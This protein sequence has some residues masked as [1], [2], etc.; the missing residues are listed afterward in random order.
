MLEHNK[1]RV[2]V[3]MASYNGLQYIDAQI[4]SI[5]DQVDCEITL[6][7]SV[8]KSDDNTFYH[9]QNFKKNDA[10]IELLA[11]GA[12]YGSAAANFYRLIIEANLEGYDYIAFADQDDIWE[13][14]KLSRHI[15]LAK[16]NGAAGVS[17]NVIAFWPDGKKKYINK[18]QSQRELDFLFESAGPGC[19]FLMTPWLLKKVRDQL[20]SENS[21]AK[22]VALHDWL[23]YAVCRA[24]GHKWIIDSNPS[25]NYRQHKNNV[26][27]ANAG[28]KA[29]W[30]RLQKLRQG[31][32]RN[33]VIKIAQIYNG[34]SPSIE[35]EKLGSLLVTKNLFTQLKLLAYLT[36]ARR[37]LLDRCLLA[38][39]IAVGIF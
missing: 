32:Y 7:I 11:Y 31:W 21:P 13:P 29:K 16:L 30:T 20:L 27:G 24:H 12:K 8:D 2:L 14:D 1:S 35:T 4:K 39:S 26:I 22:E 38:L 9:L 3:L 5:A 37:S 28:W 25:V 17:S 23:V 15:Q 33:E 18:A 19:T 34:I 10:F 36:K 6:L